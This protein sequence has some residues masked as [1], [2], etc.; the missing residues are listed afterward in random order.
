M[1]QKFRLGLHPVAASFLAVCITVLALASPAAATTPDWQSVH[2]KVKEMVAGGTTF[3]WSELGSGP[4]LL[5]LNGTASPMNEWDPA[6]LAGLSRTNRVIVFD[7]PGLGDSG[8][9]PAAWRFNAAA[10]W[11]TD[12]A[13]KVSPGFPVNIL[14]W[15]MGGF[16]AQQMAV[17]HPEIVN[18]LIL[19]ATN[20]G[21]SRTVL[22]P[23][24]VQAIDSSASSEADYLRTNY[25]PSGVAA[26]KRFLSRLTAAINSGAY[27]PTDTPA[28]TLN[29]M[30]AAEE[31]WLRSNSNLQALKTVKSPTLVLDGTQDVITPP[32]NSST[33]ASLI[34]DA[35]LVLFPKAGHSFLFQYPQKVARAINAFL[36]ENR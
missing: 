4:P 26:G 2:L 22:G 16:I 29:A 9:A 10:D 5:L 13:A 27:Q 30:V 15:S 21:S 32:A 33:L 14:G 18:A 23:T 28:R 36:T 35:K 1:R 20:P 12:F 8:P 3:A 11:I 34:P 17:R 31:P 25:P 6:F 19:A 7:Y 24:W